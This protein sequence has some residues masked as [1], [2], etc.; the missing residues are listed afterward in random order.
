[1]TRMSS[2]QFHPQTVQ[3]AR[4]IGSA[5]CVYV[6]AC[7]C[8]CGPYLPVVGAQ[9]THQHVHVFWVPLPVLTAEILQQ[10]DGFVQTVEN[11]HHSEWT[12][13]TQTHSA[14]LWQLYYFFYR[15]YFYYIM[16]SIILI[17][18]N[19]ND[20]NA[21]LIIQKLLMSI[22]ILTRYIIY[23]YIYINK[24][25]FY[26]YNIFML[27]KHAYLSFFLWMSFY[28]DI[29]FL[30][31]IH[32]IIIL[33]FIYCLRPEY[34]PSCICPLGGFISSRAG[35]RYRCGVGL[36]DRDSESRR[37][38]DFEPLL[39]SL[40]SLGLFSFVF[41]FPYLYFIFVLMW[42]TVYL[43]NLVLVWPPFLQMLLHP[44]PGGC[45]NINKTCRFIS[46]DIF[47]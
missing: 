9:L 40:S 1:M 18:I 43:L 10:T 41:F 21:I 33:A 17:I 5:G 29:V 26:K 25:C 37:G 34:S 38:L 46:T 31:I 42:L 19:I 2:A 45:N 6:C 36:K 8:V 16:Y 11:T 23:V 7:V 14:L 13:I 35:V 12:Q 22:Y 20:Q 4:V 30:I 15:F 24:S 44:E 3:Y 32:I 28:I 27:P 47:L 39:S